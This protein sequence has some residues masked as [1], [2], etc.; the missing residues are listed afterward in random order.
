MVGA[1][2]VAAWGLSDQDGEITACVNRS[3]GQLR[4]VATA[5]DCRSGSETPLVWNKQG[6]KGD[7]GPQGERGPTGEP[8]PQGVQGPQGE[9]GEKGDKGDPG[10]PG[11]QGERGLQGEQGPR[12]EVGPQGPAGAPVDGVCPSGQYLA[13]YQGGVLVCR[14]LPGDDEPGPVDA[15][16]DGVPSGEDCDDSD[17]A[18]SPLRP[19]APGNGRDDDC[20]GLVDEGSVS[21]VVV[22]EVSDGEAGSSSTARFVE[23]KNT[24]SSAVDLTGYKLVAVEEGDVARTLTF[25]DGVV[26]APGEYHV[27]TTDP[28]SVGGGSSRQPV[29]M[30][31]LP[32]SSADRG[33]TV[34]LFDAQDR[35]QDLVG[36]GFSFGGGPPW[37]YAGTEQPRFEGPS[38]PFVDEIGNLR[39][40]SRVPDG[41]DSD[42][43]RADLDTR[44]RTPG[45]PNL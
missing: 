13:G 42:D 11:P 23:L 45:T 24:S 6:V 21:G 20:D 3:T 43:N 28:F 37:S 26:L 31:F 38:A 4:V 1:G 35:R 29:P 19:E 25:V 18:V 5:A 30:S 14:D 27:L 17:P 39:S 40:V 36:F 33:T 44:S 32:N 41:R 7:P 10:E 22:N 9:Q 12:G 15:D 16:G 34:G 8:G 2:G